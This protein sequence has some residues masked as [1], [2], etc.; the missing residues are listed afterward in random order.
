M[1]DES[2]SPFEVETLLKKR[3]LPIFVFEDTDAEWTVKDEGG[4]VE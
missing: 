1:V 4:R 3:G 2:G